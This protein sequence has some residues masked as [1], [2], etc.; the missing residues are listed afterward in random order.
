MDTSALTPS[1]KRKT[2][3]IAFYSLSVL[4]TFVGAGGCGSVGRQYRKFADKPHSVTITWEQSASRV[5]G[6]NVYRADT[7]GGKFT[8]L[9]S[10]PI[11]ATMYT[12][13]AVEAGKSYTYYVAA[14]NSDGV[15]SKASENVIARVPSP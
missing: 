6:Y 3:P 9:T 12:D 7:P 13:L 14:V 4:L 1:T 2:N 15:E 5:I 10:Q 8:K 11:L